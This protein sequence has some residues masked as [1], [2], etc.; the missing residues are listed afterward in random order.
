M[1]EKLS[2]YLLALMMIFST[3]M[4]YGN[5]FLEAG[6]G[7]TLPTGSDLSEKLSYGGRVVLGWGGHLTSMSEGGALYGYGSLDYDQLIQVGPIS[8]GEPTLTRTQW[9]PT[10][11]IRLYKLLA[12]KWRVW[13]DV[14]LGKTYDRSMIQFVF[15]ST[16]TNYTGESGVFNIVGGLQYKHSPGLLFS[17][18]YDQ[19]FYFSPKQI[20]LTEK[21]LQTGRQSTLS[22]RGK[23]LMS[24][25]FYL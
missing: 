24:I 2:T 10:L 13:G 14:G 9:T 23:F 4:A 6:A 8:L 1:R 7:L 21:A 3:E 15:L 18:S 5:G 11:G 25:G 16:S 20:G 12:K 19:F 17:L 22:G